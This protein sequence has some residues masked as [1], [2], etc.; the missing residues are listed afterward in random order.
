MVGRPSQSSYGTQN[1]TSMIPVFLPGYPVRTTAS[2]SW[3]IVHIFY[4][5]FGH[6]TGLIRK[7]LLR[8]DIRQAV[9]GQRWSGSRS[10]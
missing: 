4:S 3:I 10:T 7:Y 9:G 5:S 2:V 8:P 6:G 1:V